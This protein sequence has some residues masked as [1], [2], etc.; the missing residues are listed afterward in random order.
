MVINAI[1]YK[2]TLSY[3]KNRKRFSN[4]RGLNKGGH[5]EDKVCCGHGEKQKKA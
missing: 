4:Q 2:I 3:F 5:R 1:D